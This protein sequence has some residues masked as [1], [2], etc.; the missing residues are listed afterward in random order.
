MARYWLAVVLGLWGAAWA[1]PAPPT[2]DERLTSIN[3]YESPRLGQTV[4]RLAEAETRAADGQWDSAVDAYVHLLADA[5]DDLV[6]L[7]RRHGIQVRRLCHLR[8]ANLPP[9]ALR[10]YR[11]RVDGLARKLLAQGTAARD[12]VVLRRLVDDYFCSRPTEQALDL[13]GDLAFERGD[14]EAAQ[15]WWRMLVPPASASRGAEAGKAANGQRP[16]AGPI[17]PRF[18][19]V[20]PDPQGDVAQV[21]AKQFLA[22]LFSG[23]REPVEVEWKAFQTLHA[24][25]AGHLAGRDGN[26]VENLQTLL[27]QADTLTVPPGEETWSTFAGDP[28]R[29]RVLPRADRRL[30]V[31]PEGEGPQWTAQLR[32][33]LRIKPNEVEPPAAQAARL[34]AY[35]PVLAGNQV[36]VADGH[37]I[38]AYDL[39]SGQENWHEDLFPNER[40]GDLV[41]DRR[42]PGPGP[43]WTLTVA[44]DRVYARL[45][46]PPPKLDNPDNH[47]YLVCLP[48]H[49]EAANHPPSWKVVS[50]GS[51]DPGP[52][53]AGAPVVGRGRVYIA[54]CRFQGGQVS[55]AIA[56]YD[57]ESGTR[58]W[59][60]QVC[61][62]PEPA[63]TT[64]RFH[65]HL[66]TLAGANVVYCSHSGAIVAV[67]AQSGR[68]IWA[69][70]YPSRGVRTETGAYTPRNLA[71]A[72]CA[73][74]RLF[75]APLDHDRILCLDVETGAT[76]WESPRTEVIH[77]LGVARGR[78]IFTATTPYPCIRAVDATT[79]SSAGGWLQPE[80]APPDDDK[81][82]S[83]GRGLLVGEYV[84]WP[85]QEGLRVLRQEDGEPVAGDNPNRIHG[86]LA[87]ANGCLVAAG[88]DHLTAYLPEGLLLKQ[89]Q[90]E[91]AAAPRS[92][93]AR[94]RLALAEADAGQASQAV[95]NLA[96]VESLAG[97]EERWHGFRLRQQARKRRQEV[98]LQ[99]AG[100]ARGAEQ[101]DRALGFLERAAAKD[102]A[103]PE[104]LTALEQQAAFWSM[105]GQPARAV[106]VWQSILTD[107]TLRNSPMNTAD[108]NPQR[109][110]L[111]A[112]ERIDVLIRKHGPEIYQAVEEQAQALL[113]AGR[114]NAAVLAQLGRDYPNAAVTRPA[115]LE[116]GQQEEQAGRLGAAAQAYRQVLFHAGADAERSLA[117]V[118]LARAYEHEHCW[119]AARRTWQQLAAEYG[120]QTLTEFDPDRTV[121][122]AVAQQLQKPAYRP[123]EVATLP[124]LALPL[125]RSW[126]CLPAA[127]DEHFLVPQANA[128]QEEADGSFYSARGPVVICRDP[129]TGQTRWERRLSSPAIWVAGHADTVLVAGAEHIAC[130]RRADGELIWEWF[131]EV[132]PSL[133]PPRFSLG[134][135]HLAGSRLFCLQDERRLFALDVERGQVLWSV[136]APAARWG[137]STSRGRFGPNYYASSQG[138]VV[139]TTGG[140][141]WVLD[142]RTGRKL[143]EFPTGAALWR[144]PPVALDEHRV[145]VVPDSQPYAQQVVMLDP[146]TGQEQ[147]TCSVERPVSLAGEAPLLLGNGQQLLMLVS[148][149]YGSFLECLS[150]LTGTRRWPEPRFLGVQPVDLAAGTM[151]DKAIY[152]VQQKA[153]HAYALADGKHLWRCALPDGV[154][155]WRLLRTRDHVI[156]CPAQERAVRWR[157]VW[158]GWAVQ[159]EST[160]AGTD[161]E[162]GTYP[163]LLCDPQTGEWVQ[164]LNVTTAGVWGQ[165]ART[166]NPVG[167][168]VPQITRERLVREE[169]ATGVQLSGQGLIVALL[170]T[171]WGMAASEER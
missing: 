149:N 121:R 111:V 120:G 99:L 101:W 54:E 27:A 3:L 162:A 137:R 85:T 148:R 81:L 78:L 23:L 97:A 36:L 139:Q 145:C 159:L 39:T 60:H 141:A 53:F 127:P 169:A 95:E 170:D 142:S 24:K 52:G 20:F 62:T 92:A 50:E 46:G 80:I 22:Q 167:S 5:G 89:R 131:P 104:R 158:L 75:V 103:G 147:W 161:R 70:R 58:R 98:L 68:R 7:D 44:E 115:L 140:K 48:L 110:E 29:N 93:L 150:P 77:L 96:Q 43:R 25:A 105:R 116:L 55:S 94:Y 129:Q 171:A 42:T 108:G 160:R 63:E 35:Y 165:V 163:V 126:Q 4:K 130:L 49:P 79:G 134:R 146:A 143:R 45:I 71:P 91:A 118:G 90:K 38:T 32:P 86:N 19:L 132:S 16:E 66:L 26:Y 166:P 18:Q 21:R 152:L 114:K 9:A 67:D 168:L 84:F 72:V 65:Q 59:R 33:A 30:A 64:G 102:F 8:L 15:R 74:G 56:C 113:A 51:A 133:L 135:F 164:R 138:L 88:I 153:L 87:A 12:P 61:E 124:C 69:V 76:F 106:A 2:E 107:A 151:D 13:L 10:L 122:E 112:Q 28:S 11:Q 157:M 155:H 17:P 83:F 117:L 41:R 109:A 31:L 82:V 156:A 128:G 47:S 125:T 154:E 14:F 144:Q 73:G 34:L 119:N 1:E 123:G 136:W 37:S 100:Q 40:Q 6:P 57:A